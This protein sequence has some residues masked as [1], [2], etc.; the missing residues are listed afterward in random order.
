[1]NEPHK[2]SG[3]SVPLT[4]QLSFHPLLVIYG[5]FTDTTA[6]NRTESQIEAM[7]FPEETFGTLVNYF[8][9]AS[10]HGF[11]LVP[12]LERGGAV[13]DDAVDRS[14]GSAQ[15]VGR[16]DRAVH[17]A[18]DQRPLAI[19]QGIARFAEADALRLAHGACVADRETLGGKRRR[20]IRERGRGAADEGGDCS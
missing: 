14:R 17:V 15:T 2:F 4:W 9:V 19:E 8:K 5:T 1:M 13:A 7:F 3:S 16:A 18:A 12:A 6:Q 20:R 11:E 10:S